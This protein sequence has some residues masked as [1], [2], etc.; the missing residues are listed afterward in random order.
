MK[1]TQ[2][3][4]FFIFCITSSLS[5]AQ[6]GIDGNRIVNAAGT[7]VNEYTTLTADAAIGATTITVGASGLNANVRFGA[8]NTLAAGDLI[9]IIQMQ[10]TTILGA[11]DAFTPTISN[12]NDA[13]W[14]GVTNYNNTGRFEYCQVSSVPSATTITVDCG[15]INNYTAAGRVQVIRIPRYNTLL[16]QSPGILTCQSWNGTTGGV[17]AV[18]VYGNTTITA[19]GKI[20]TTGTGFRGGALFTT[21]GRTT[22]TLY[23]CISLDVGTNKGE[24][25]A[26]YQADYTPYGG[27][28]CRG[29][30]A[31]A[32][33]GGNVWNCGGG[34]G[35][36]ASLAP[37]WTGQGNPNNT[38]AAWTTAWNLESAGF[39]A[40]T[41]SGGGRGGYSFSSSNQNATVLGPG[42]PGFTNA[43]GGSYRYNLGG[44]GG[45]GLDYSTGR[46]FLG[47]GGGAGEQDNAQGG[48][49]GAGGGIIY[50]TSY[51]TIT[52]SGN[53]SIISNGANGGSSL[54]TGTNSGRDAAGGA[55]GGGAILINSVGN[56]SGVFIKANGGT[57]GHQLA[58]TSGFFPLT[59][60]EG[61]GG[62]GGGGYIGVTSGPPAGSQQ[63]LGGVNGI[64]QSPHVTEFLPNGATMGG[65]GLT[66]QAIV[67][68]DTISVA[69]A[70]I[71]SGNTAT[72]TA[73]I[74]GSIPATVTWYNAQAGGTVLGTGAT[75]T[76]PVLVATTTYYVG[77]CPGTYTIPVT[78]TVNTSPTA[79]AAGGDQT[80]CA[81]SAT[82]AGNTPTAGTGTWTLISG[83]GT[84]TTPT[85]PTSTV[86]ALGLGANVFQW[87]ISNPP[88]GTSTDQ[89]T[90][91]S[92]GGPT[93]SAAGTDQIVC[94]T[95]ATLAGNTPTTGTGLWTLVS[96][97]GT[98]T[99]PSSPTSGITGLGVGPNVFQWTI[100][101][102]PCAP[103]TDQVTITGIAAP[104]TA[105]AGPDQSVCGTTA[106]LAGN[107][108]ATGTGIWTLVSGTGIIT[109]P[110]SPTSG[111]TAL[112]VGANVFQWTIAN[113]PCPST[114]DQVTITGV[115]A[116]TV[117]AAGPDQSV[118]GTTATLAGNT[119]TTGTGT[120]TLVS[121]TGTITTPS[122]PTSG[123]TGLG[124]GAN[125]F[126]W[127]I[128]NA[129]CPSSTDQT[130]ITG[131]AAPTVSNAGP[132]QTVCATSA[133]LA[134]NTPTTGTGTW[135][136]VSGAGT[137][138]TPSSPTSGVTGLGAGPNV[139]QWTISNAPCAPSSST[140][141]IDNTGGPTTSAAGP[142]QT[143]CGT[144]ATLAGNTPVVG[145]GA[146]TLVSGAGTITTPSSPT[147]G[148]TGLGVGAN[149]FQ[150][151][152]TN[153][154]CPPSTSTVTIIGVASPTT[155][156][157][158]PNQTVCGTTATLAGNTATVGTGTW[159]LVSGA[160]TITT[161]SSPTSGITG[162]GIGA[163]VF[164]W[165]IDN[166]PC[167]ASSSSVTITG[168]A[169]PTVSNAGPNQTLCG[170]TATLAGNTATVGTGTWTLVS[171]TGTITT[172]TSP[173]SGLTGLA[174]GANVFQWTI[175][176]APCP[177][178]TSTVTITISPAADATITSVSPICIGTSSFNLSAATAGGIW[179]G[180]GIT[181]TINGTF[182]PATAGVGTY[183]ITYTISG[184]CGN[185]D[186]TI[187]SVIPNDDATITPSSSLC[188]SAAPVNF[189][190]AT[191][192]GTWTGTGITDTING[193]F[194]PAIAGIGSYTITYTISGSCGDVDT[195]IVNVTSTSDATIIP[196]ATICVGTPS[197]NL[198]SVTTGG[199]WSGTGITDTINGTFNSTTAGVGVHIITYT[200][201]GT[202]GA[203]DTVSI[204]V[205]ASADA[206]ITSVSPIC[207]DASP[208]NL[209]AATAGGTWSGTG[210]TDAVNGTFDPSLASLG[211]NTI[212]YSIGGACGDTA[213]QIVTVNGLPTP[214]FTSDV[215]SGCA[216]IC[217][218]FTEAG[219]NTCNTVSYDFGD[220]NTSTSSTATNCYAHAGIYSVTLTCTDLNGCVG[221]IIVPNM[222]TVAPTP[223]ADF[224]YSPTGVSPV[225][226]SVTFTDISTGGGISSWTFGDPLSGSNTSS[227][228]SDSHTYNT[229]GVFCI[230]LIASNT[231]GCADT[232]SEC[233]T[234]ADEATILIPNIFTP[235]NDGVND[236]FYFTTT[237]VKELTC[238]IYD[239]WGLK[240]ASFTATND[241]INGWDGRTTSGLLAPD[242]VYYYIMKAE[243]LNNKTIDQTGFI[244][245]FQEK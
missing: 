215:T 160:G 24:G 129:P 112:G 185:V 48:A 135:T 11:P 224:S 110:T 124:V 176:N 162:L 137:I 45:R 92:T 141:T 43:W 76:T 27:R 5:Y 180:T 35:A 117:S 91:T 10:G 232:T 108:A 95:T 64:S 213:T 107:T 51:G 220:G 80:V 77:F 19:G 218:T 211:A 6:R 7:I 139:F 18:E 238:N 120:W 37:V 94:G 102:A 172:P 86:T 59:E 21:T 113:A 206:S 217:V 28:Y 46:I 192:G 146:W 202:C 177:P 12:P 190:A 25:I 83:S 188:V 67:R 164:Q 142:N 216:P 114:T 239:R 52:G 134:G 145:T 229:E 90:I 8:G 228:A 156:N 144:T 2:R 200:I 242:G 148:V 9:M 68:V 226:T 132:N 22:T 126:Q 15:L 100:S 178:S 243:T 23:S 30:A 195:M 204:T 136:L 20:N 138:T 115:A 183:T 209:N 225:G 118:C 71:C 105:A 231:S 34:G 166:A 236:I 157:A 131:V 49:G 13:T 16:I 44:L 222:V 187:V 29:A 98:I 214:T 88:C 33:G 196:P 99:T 109:T 123:V 227:L 119:A 38:I 70:T 3:L 163:N 154:P 72:L 158:G 61:P 182:D 55:G 41:S 63:S 199:I 116:P 121:G 173:T 152:I 127:T 194:N 79:S 54:N 104:T 175:D 245:L 89:V 84:I 130:T 56:V 65:A 87:T 155:S 237:S 62:G 221:I 69:N 81:T 14:G 171:G 153:A 240:I 149:V 122:S 57:G 174:V 186:T 31:N 36:N 60:A 181:D 85:S 78:V 101:S 97:A 197:F 111:V 159:T 58:N 161:P 169:S 167:P 73:T 201:S 125:V 1:R 219:T 128:A 74:N 4:L 53:D 233:I 207:A 223:V 184:A 103:S 47:G 203:M 168:V 133:T 230:T 241:A 93:T 96:G 42:T 191:A 235:N 26:G 208:F 205:T 234:I 106:T 39:A 17:L 179:T 165:T 151:T 193:T 170:T 143:V 244:H 189:T 82:L 40:S 212:T 66:N 140:V 210:I 150:W 32:G 50:I 198:S 75:F 147:S